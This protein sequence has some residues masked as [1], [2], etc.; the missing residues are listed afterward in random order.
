MLCGW[1]QRPGTSRRRHPSMGEAGMRAIIA[2]AVA[3]LVGLGSAAAQASD[4]EGRARVQNADG[5]WC[6]FDQT[7]EKKKAAFLGPLQAEIAT[8]TFEDPSCMTEVLDDVGDLAGTI[9]RSSIAR[10]IASMAR[11]SWVQD[12]VKYDPG[13]RNHPGMMQK[14]GECMVADDLPA[15]AI[16]INFVSNGIAITE[17]E[18]AHTF[19][20]GDPL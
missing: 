18:Y 15:T 12:W 7:V 1:S 2:A 8:M 4:M 19:G 9:N 11:I 3:G 17:V 10:S 5:G 6:W 20:C 13:K 16:A 14:T